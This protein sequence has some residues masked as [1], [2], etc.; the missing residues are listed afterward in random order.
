MGGGGF[1]NICNYRG[2]VGL[3]KQSFK[4]WRDGES[5]ICDYGRV[6]G[7]SPKSNYGRRGDTNN[8]QVME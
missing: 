1:I 7:G 2:P 5:G 3:C 4:L 6:G 8:V